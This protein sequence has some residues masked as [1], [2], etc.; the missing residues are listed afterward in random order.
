VAVRAV[1]GT[2]LSRY[3]HLRLFGASGKIVRSEYATIIQHPNGRQK[4]IASRNNRIDVYPYDDDLTPKDKA[5]NNFLYYSTDTLRGSSGSPVFS[6]QWYVVALHR[7]G[8]PETATVKGKKVVL[9]TNKKPAATDDPD[10]VIS[11]ISNEG[12]RISRILARVDDLSQNAKTPELRSDAA[13]VRDAVSDAAG[14][15]SDGPF[16]R[17][18]A[19]MIVMED[20][21]QTVRRGGGGGVVESFEI[22]HRKIEL[23][24][25]NT[26]YDK[27][28]LTGHAIPLPKPSASLRTELAPRLDK[29]A[30]F[31]LPFRHFTTAMHARRRLPVFAAINLDGKKMPDG[32]MP[33]RPGWSFD[34]R[35][36][37]AHQPDD[38]IFSDMLQRGH[39]A[40][41]ES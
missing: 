36:D 34:P 6:D 18:S 39:M 9:R 12:V 3:G 40:A 13:R 16:S 26:G 35:I 5:A 15:P 27:N 21:D 37:Q 2:P 32:A 29:P 19:T 7:R 23:F 20:P 8:V 33:D 14:L 22:S 10:E 41:R 4:H 24:P 17:L 31:L 30:E 28:F 11:Y 38:T 25:E 1:D